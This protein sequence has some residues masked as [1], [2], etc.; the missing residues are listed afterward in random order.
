MKDDSPRVNAIAGITNVALLMQLVD[1]VQNRPPF[2]A[3]IGVFSGYSGFGKTMAAT[4]AAN[5][6]DAVVIELDSTYTTK[7]LFSLLAR[8]LGLPGKGTAAALSD[9]IAAEL[10]SCTRPVILDE[11]DHLLKRPKMLQD[12]RGL[13][14]KA[15]ATLILIGEENLPTAL[16][17][18]ERVAGRVLQY[19]QAQP[20][21]VDD[22]LLLADIYA[23]GIE[24]DP[25]L[26][27]EL[28]KAS[29]SSVRRLCNNLHHIREAARRLGR[30]AMTA[31]DLDEVTFTTGR[32]PSARRGL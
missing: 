13:F 11:A 32:P 6:F 1:T 4:V 3:N 5:E 22:A 14:D 26:H 24:I 15:Q 27:A 19:V 31:D 30:A 20:A 23:P 18:W 2:L 17:Q 21:S 25:G 8:E 28:M 9:A 12:V 29:G 16:L 10:I 7:H